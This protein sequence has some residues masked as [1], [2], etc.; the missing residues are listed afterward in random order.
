[1]LEQ[2]GVDERVIIPRSS[3]LEIIPE[4][5][6]AW[7]PAGRKVARVVDV[8]TGSGCLAILLAHQFRHAQV[9]AC[10]LS[11]AALEVAKINVQAHRL[12][13]RVH[14]HLSDVLSAVPA[15]KYDVILSNP[16]YE[17]SGLVDAQAPEFAA[18]P[19]LAHDGGRDGLGII[20]RLLEQAR[21]RL[22]RS[23]DEKQIIVRQLP[24][25]SN[26]ER[27]GFVGEEQRLNWVEGLRLSNQQSQLFGVSYQI[28]AQQPY[29]FASELNPGQ[30]TIHHSLMKIN[31]NL[32]HE[33]DLM[34]LLSTLGKQGAGFFSV[35]QCQMDRSGTANIT[36]GSAVRYQPNLRAEC[37]LSWMTVTAPSVPN[38]AEKKP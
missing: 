28:G 21:T 15:A 36:A 32:L 22:Q 5:L 30:L 11:P 9:D 26:L 34:R 31:F 12:G 4:Q 3:F 6:A 16:P 35:N 23:G 27:I 29:P 17:P 10:D 14:L 2:I 20:R 38:A 7:L 1:M 25:Y 18:E 37:D 24:S 13:R 8:G 33:G 19:R